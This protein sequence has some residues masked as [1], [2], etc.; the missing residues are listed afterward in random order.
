MAE[1]RFAFTIDEDVFMVFVIDPDN[2]ADPNAKMIF[3]GLSSDPKIIPIP[4]D[5]PVI[6]MRTIWNGSEFVGRG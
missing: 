5:V 6:A 4:D 2:E 1:K 3:A